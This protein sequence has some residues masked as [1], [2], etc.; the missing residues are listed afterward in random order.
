M[1]PN[2]RLLIRLSFVDG[3]MKS[4]GY[5][6]PHFEFADTLTASIKRDFADLPAHTEIRLFYYN[7][8]GVV[9]A[10]S[11]EELADTAVNWLIGTGYYNGN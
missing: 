1:Q 5:D 6:Y 11:G 9:T 2:T 4:W 8:E 3:S 10:N 7:Q